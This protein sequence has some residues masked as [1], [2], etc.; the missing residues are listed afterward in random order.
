MNYRPDALDR[1]LLDRM[2]NGIPLTEKVWDSIGGEVGI[3]GSEVLQR[4][5]RLRAAHI[6]RGIGPVIE[7]GEVGLGASSLI[8]LRVAPERIQTVAAIINAY[9]EV[10]HNYQRDHTY[11]LWFTL[12]A[13]SPQE[14]T[15]V[16][17]EICRR[18]G[19][20]RED[21]LDLPRRKRFKINVRF[22]IG[23]NGARRS[24]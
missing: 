18:A 2:Q 8:A 6:L 19:L 22:R 7:P 23:G 12:T 13:S 17:E 20:E 14:L 24:R 3:T 21:V 16:R 4:I 11:N 1:A 5:R 15:R 9:E 10:S